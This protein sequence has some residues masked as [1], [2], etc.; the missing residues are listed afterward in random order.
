MDYRVMTGQGGMMDYINEY[1]GQISW[2]GLISTSLRILLVMV[3][4]WLL[5]NL[6][7]S[8]LKRLEQRLLK[9]ANTTGEL[10]SEAQKRAERWCD[11]CARG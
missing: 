1:L 3:G 9:N 8:A 2:E 6:V 5:S 10:P 7:R 4:L 11:F